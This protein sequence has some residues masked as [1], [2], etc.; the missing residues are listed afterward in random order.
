MKNVYCMK[1]CWQEE[2]Q[3]PVTI[4]RSFSRSYKW[5]NCSNDIGSFD[6]FLTKFFAKVISCFKSFSLN[7]Y[8]SRILSSVFSD[9][10]VWPPGKRAEKHEIM[11]SESLQKMRS[12]FYEVA[13]HLG[14]VK[15]VVTK[16]LR[17]MFRSSI[18]K[19]AERNT[20]A[21]KNSD[22]LTETNS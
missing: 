3:L 11:A 2:S 13:G 14:R 17:K 6:S 12:K 15:T 10:N 8:D 1:H 16:H 20:A 21:R 5:K 7:E 4:K 19:A 22:K 18:H 9:R